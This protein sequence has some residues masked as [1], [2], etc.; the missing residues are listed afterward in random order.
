M[1]K[2]FA[3]LFA[4]C[5]LASHSVSAV[6]YGWYIQ[7]Y[8]DD[9]CTTETSDFYELSADISQSGAGS[10]SLLGTA[11][12][13]TGLLEVESYVDDQETNPLPTITLPD[14]FTDATKTGCFQ[15]NNVEASV[16]AFDVY[17][18]LIVDNTAS[19]VTATLNLYSDDQC[20]TTV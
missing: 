13:A 2:F 1:S 15:L 20:T 3:A 8:E 6:N 16:A 5:L 14:V 12:V 10:Y 17:A 7:G 9:T 11:T 18:Q 4:V 19:P